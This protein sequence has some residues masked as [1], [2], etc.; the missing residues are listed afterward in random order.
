MIL[1]CHQP[2]FMPYLGYFYKL[3]LC[4]VYSVSNTCGFTNH[5]DNGIHNYNFI[6]EFGQRKKLTIPVDK[7]SGR[8]CDV[9]IATEYEK[10]DRELIL[11]RLYYSY[12]KCAYFNVVYSDIKKILE[13]FKAGQPMWELNLTITRLIIEKMGM[14]KKIVIESEQEDL[15]DD[16]TDAII[17]MCKRTGCNQYLAGI[18]GN[19]Y[20]NLDKFKE[21]GIEIIYSDF[22]DEKDLTGDKLSIID[23]LMNYGYNIP[24]EWKNGK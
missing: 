6:K 13:E 19:Q 2:N 20:M 18:H 17:Y 16:P 24:K 14:N 8:I 22:N 21:N 23:Y 12:H 4:D 11:K 9:N 3:Y 15:P 1:T 10:R 5:R 7:H